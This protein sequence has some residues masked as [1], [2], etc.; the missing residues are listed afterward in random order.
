MCR[1]LLLDLVHLHKKDSNLWLRE[2]KK[3]LLDP[4]SCR[5]LVPCNHYIWDSSPRILAATVLPD[6]RFYRQIWAKLAK[7][8]PLWLFPF[9]FGYFPDLAIC[10]AILRFFIDEAH[11]FPLNSIF[12]LKPSKSLY[13]EKKIYNF[14]QLS[15]PTSLEILTPNLRK[16]VS[17]GP[18]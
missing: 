17:L 12:Y 2:G 1:N 3:R 9:I 4:A 14:C 18:T 7:F 10:L 15:P 8:D 6:R 13:K 5:E 11:N 16:V